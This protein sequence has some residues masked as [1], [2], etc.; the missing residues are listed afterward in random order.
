MLENRVFVWFPA[1]HLLKNTHR[2][3]SPSVVYLPLLIRELLLNK[4]KISAHGKQGVAPRLVLRPDADGV[5]V[6]GG[7]LEAAPEAVDK[8]DHV[9]YVIDGGEVL[10]E[11]VE[12]VLFLRGE[13]GAREELRDAATTQIRRRQ[14]VGGC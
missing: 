14:G 7:A 2:A 13:G 9:F 1:R 10:E 12:E 11:E 5:Q 3:L 6:V 4:R 8:G